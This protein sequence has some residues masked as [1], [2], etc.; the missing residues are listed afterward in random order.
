MLG[1]VG[2]PDV[3][4]DDLSWTAGVHIPVLPPQVL[5]VSVLEQTIIDNRKGIFVLEYHGTGGPASGTS[6]ECL[7]F[8]L[9]RKLTL[10]VPDRSKLIGGAV[11]P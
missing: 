3:H 7:P 10:H 9:K 4:G 1:G 11:R 2:G 5:T 8:E 6:S